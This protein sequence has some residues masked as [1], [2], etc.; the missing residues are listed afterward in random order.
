MRAMVSALILTVGI[1]LLI[2]GLSAS[3]S[4]SSEVSR[5]FRG[6]PSDRATLFLVIGGAAT[7]AGLVGVFLTF[8]SRPP[9]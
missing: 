2:L 9:S 3:G 5:T 7:V 8:R 4:F 1:A 6:T